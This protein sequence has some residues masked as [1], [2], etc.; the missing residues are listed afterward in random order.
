MINDMQK[1]VEKLIKG[2]SWMDDEAKDFALAKVKNLK[3]FIGYPKWYKNTT[4]IQEY[5]KEVSLSKIVNISYH[6]MMTL[7]KIIPLKLVIG[8]SYYE[9]VLRYDKWSKRKSLQKLF[10][11]NEAEETEEE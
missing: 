1:E 9:N 2:S 5:Y 10:K 3:R 11:N 7:H 8:S 4:I 6:Y